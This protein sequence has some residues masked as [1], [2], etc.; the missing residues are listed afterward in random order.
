MNSPVPV[1]VLV[2]TKNEGRNLLRCLEALRGWADEIVVADSHSVDD[3]VTIAESSGA[4]LVQFDY[5]GGWPKKRQFVLDTHPFRNEW[6]LLLDADEILLEPV[7]K[8][9]AK[10]VRTSE[11]DGYW[12]KFQIH[13]LGRQLR[14]GD[15]E[16]WKLSLFRRARGRYEKRLESQDQ[17]MSDVE[18][19]EHIILE[20]QTG[21]LKNPV[22]HENW[23]SLSRY[24][25]KH[26][27]Y[28]N[29]EARVQRERLAGEIRPAFWGI[30]VQRRRWLKRVLLWLPGSPLLLFV[31]KYFLKLGV[32]DGVP[33]LIYSSFQAIQVFHVKSKMYEMAVSMLYPPTTDP[34]PPAAREE[35]ARSRS[36]SPWCESFE[37]HVKPQSGRQ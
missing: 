27:E 5:R 31:Y 26:D 13:F 33:G 16:L 34:N 36:T 3:T 29:W 23:N 2:P 18:V 37:P 35:T 7:K 9:I 21:R 19:H 11:L 6:I 17:S 30:Q 22:R 25:Q 1:S 14:F 12:L 15:T 8:E 32:L 28:S 10:V 20:G 4:A 24:I